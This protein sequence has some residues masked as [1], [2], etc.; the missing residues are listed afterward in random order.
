MGTEKDNYRE[1]Q[2]FHDMGLIGRK[3]TA[4]MQSRKKGKTEESRTSDS[5]ERTEA[6]MVIRG[7]GGIGWESYTH[8]PAEQKIGQRVLNKCSF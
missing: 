5:G 3:K 6:M 8:H 2:A 4:V 7:G 1:H